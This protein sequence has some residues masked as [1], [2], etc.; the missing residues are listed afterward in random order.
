MM[1]DHDR[2]FVFVST[3]KAGTHT[4][5]A[6]LSENYG[7]QREPGG[8]HRKDAPARCDDYFV[9]STARNPY[10]RAVSVWWH[11]LFRD[12]YRDQ[13]RPK[14]GTLDFLG[15]LKWMVN[16]PEPPAL[17]GDVVLRPQMAWLCNVRLDRILH[18]EQ[19][20]PE[21]NALPF[22]EAPIE[23]ARRLSSGA[24]ADVSDYGDW[25]SV[26]ACGGDG[27]AKQ[28]AALVRQWDRKTFD[29]CG[30]STDWTSDAIA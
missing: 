12:R 6:A 23:I 28:A 5:F 20:E 17:R 3:P 29:R 19:I 7:L 27:Y 10:S 13:W 9:F 22:V 4:V 8:F 14:I 24:A 2:R 11:L 18:I 15:F 21:F 26:F 16:H 25:R 30:Y 1:I